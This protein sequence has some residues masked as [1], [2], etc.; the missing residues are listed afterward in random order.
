MLAYGFR[1]CHCKADATFLSSVDIC[2]RGR[3]HF[4]LPPH[5]L[6]MPST[7]EARALYA[8]ANRKQ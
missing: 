7:S 6:T 8:A 4:L 1:D 3:P 2:L 5:L